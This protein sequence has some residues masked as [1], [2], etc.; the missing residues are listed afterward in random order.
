MLPWKRRMARPAGTSILLSEKGLPPLGPDMPNEPSPIF[1][2][3]HISDHD[4]ESY[5]LGMIQD[6][7]ELASVEEHLLACPDCVDRAES[8]QDYVD[9][10]RAAI[11]TDSEE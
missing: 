9:A 6:E 8:T 3:H 4:L 10:L 2:H 1:G 5:Y 7:A 11:V